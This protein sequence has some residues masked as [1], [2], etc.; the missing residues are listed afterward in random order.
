MMSPA[1]RRDECDED[2]LSARVRVRRREREERVERGRR[3]LW[4]LCCGW[5]KS[6]ALFGAL[7]RRYLLT[8]LDAAT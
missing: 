5:R 6:E 3:A 1:T 7:A 4:S 2:D 8:A